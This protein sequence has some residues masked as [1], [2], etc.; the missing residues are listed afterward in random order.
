MNDKDD[1]VRVGFWSGRDDAE[2]ERKGPPGP[3]WYMG[4]FLPARC[5]YRT[6]SKRAEW[7]SEGYEKGRAP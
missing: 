3:S 2:E 5:P 7:W 4:Q 6:G 1:A